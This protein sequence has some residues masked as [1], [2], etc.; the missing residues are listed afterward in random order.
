MRLPHLCEMSRHHR[1]GL[2]LPG[3]FL[4]ELGGSKLRQSLHFAPL[5][6]LALY[7]T[8]F[9]LALSAPYSV[10]GQTDNTRYKGRLPCANGGAERDV[11]A[12]CI[13]IHHRLPVW[14]VKRGGRDELVT[15]EKTPVA[16]SYHR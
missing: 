13:V 14:A 4:H 12:A 2:I 5:F 11:Q 10:R 6:G 1:S 15:E 7:C 8:S 16:S 3:T 9:E